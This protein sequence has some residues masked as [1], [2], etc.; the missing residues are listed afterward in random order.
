ME[1]PDLQPKDIGVDV[2]I[3]IKRNTAASGRCCENAAAS[4]ARSIL[5]Q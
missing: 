2:R 1:G 4:F 5:A 3:G